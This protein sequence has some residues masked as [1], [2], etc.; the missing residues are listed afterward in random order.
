M[1]ALV[2]I[3]IIVG[4]IVA[5]IVN[6]VADYIPARRHHFE[7]KANPFVSE[8]AIPPKPSVLPRRPDGI[9][10]PLIYWSGI[11]SAIAK[12][13]PVDP[14]FRT[15]RIIVELAIPI[16]FGLI[17]QTYGAELRIWYLLY[18]AAVLVTIAVIDIEHRWVFLELIVPT[19]I[20]ALIQA[21][22]G[23]SYGWQNTLRGGGVAFAVMMLFYVLGLGF[24]RLM[25]VLSG[26]RIS[27]TVFGLGDVYIGTMGGFI[28][29]FNF[30]GL[31]LGAMTFFGALAA[32]IFI[33]NKRLR[34]G[35]YRRFS[36]MPYGPYVALGIAVV[37]YVP[38]IVGLVVWGIF[39]SGR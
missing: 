21:L 5:V 14:Q 9:L 22:L 33:L 7:A 37:L 11:V 38:N 32:I 3:A 13:D 35:R 30:L 24:A 8:S 6:R 23:L 31:M 36:A 2:P 18:Y 29:G 1:Q 16:L 20:I 19:C 17:T 26:K 4:F 10:W 25:G 12:V 34:R 27:R 28:V 15:R 39:L